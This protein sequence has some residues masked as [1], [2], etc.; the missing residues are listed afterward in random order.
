MLDSHGLVL[1]LLWLLA[2]A[3]V[4]FFVR[5]LNQF[6]VR[7]DLER[8]THLLVMIAFTGVVLFG[9]LNFLWDA[10]AAKQKPVA[11][12]STAEPVVTEEEVTDVDAF[13]QSHHSTLH[14]VRST[15]QSR[16]QTLQAFFQ[17]VQPL[18]QDCPHMQSFL[19][20]IVDIRWGIQ[21]DFF[22]TEKGVNLSLQEF[23]IYHSTG[24]K[25]YVAR[26]FQDTADEL[27]NQI[28]RSLALD[29]AT[30]KIEQKKIQAM[31]KSASQQLDNN[32]IPSNPKNKRKPFAF[33]PY[34]ES[35]IV[36]LRTWLSNRSQ[37][38]LGIVEQIDKLLENQQ[39]IQR[40][41]E[42]IQ[43]SLKTSGNEELRK[44][45]Q[46]VV[47]EWVDTSR[48]NQY[49]LYQILYAAELLYVLENITGKAESPEQKET[50]QQVRQLWA[51]LQQSA[52][53]IV[54][55]AWKKRTEGVERSYSPTPFFEGKSH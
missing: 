13:I 22:K 6:L 39:I 4:V 15:L 8:D 24:E 25:A 31:L 40:K 16:R 35:S 52:P 50:R 9:V 2:A 14:S 5:W 45:M 18:A 48:E 38:E 54:D 37:P 28:Q 30:D 17:N 42:A 21:Q 10:G 27:V 11:P 43:T 53:L 49:A 3:G 44:A 47:G 55:L 12:A 19:Q 36:L 46:D 1:F 51:Q 29:D 34:R 41:A 23:W 26:A 20:E 7:F 33:D 32:G